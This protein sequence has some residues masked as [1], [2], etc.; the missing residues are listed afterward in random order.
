[1]PRVLVGPT[2]ADMSNDEYGK[3]YNL[4]NN[5]YDDDFTVDTYTRKVSDRLDPENVTV[6]PL[7]GSNR[8]TYYARLYRTLLRELRNRPVD[9][10]HHMNLSYRWFNP[11]LVSGLQNDI[12]VV[13]GP[14]QAGHAIM[15]EEFNRMISSWVGSDLPRPLTD[16][17]HAAVDATRDAVLDPP[18][19]DLFKRTLEA[20]DRVVV[21]H[22]E[23]REVYAEFVDE[24]K[25]RTIPLGVD[26]DFFE[27]S[28][29]ADSKELVA[30]GSLRERKG[31]D[32]LFEALDLIQQ[33][34]PAVHLNVFGDGPLEDELHAQVE[35]LNLAA[36][37][38]FH[39]YVDQ[40]VVREH[41]S[42]ARAFVHPSR[43][44]S[45]SLVRLEAMSTGCPVVVT[46]ISGAREMVRDGEEGFVV[47][48]ESPEPIADAV[49]T[50]LSDYELTK[51]ISRQARDR[52]EEKYDWRKIAG[53]YLDLYRSLS[54]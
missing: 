48:T 14:C 9:I 6:Y 26:P 53:E 12:P 29:P 17:L 8:I 31:Y 28:E 51:Q 7:G 21:V 44:E 43:S 5:L 40:S 46:D 49:T 10:Y 39:G 2:K 30:I 25:L 15:A 45:F 11:L 34:H 16:P 37:V 13:I 3:S 27:Y 42:R 24:S 22:E 36:N 50:L 4:L 38:T 35:Q 52:V 18:R 33:E 41:L 19:M 54:G 47:P 1:M 32:I 23:A 20:A